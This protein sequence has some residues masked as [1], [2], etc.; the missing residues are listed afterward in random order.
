MWYTAAQHP[1]VEVQRSSPVRVR[2]SVT[3]PA[4][5][6]CR[7]RSTAERSTR[8]GYCTIEAEFGS[9]VVG[10]CTTATTTP[11]LAFLLLV[12][13]FRATRRSITARAC[14]FWLLCLAL[15]VVVEE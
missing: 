1:T 15:V 10:C 7:N 8:V 6:G 12:R 14:W 3:V 2:N 13:F 9:V 5:V 11:S 4:A